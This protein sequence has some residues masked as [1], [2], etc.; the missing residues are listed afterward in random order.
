MWPQSPTIMAMHFGI[1]LVCFA[2]VFLLTRVFYETATHTPRVRTSN[3]PLPLWYRRATWTALVASIGVAYIG[4]YMRH[5]DATLACYR[6]PACTDET[7]P[8]LSGPVAVAMGH[9]L[10]ALA[11]IFLVGA[12]ARHTYRHREIEPDLYRINA[13]AFILI[14]LQALSGGAVV[15]TRL[16]TWSPL[17]HAALMALLFLC[18]ADA[19]RQIAQRSRVTAEQRL[20]LATATGQQLSPGD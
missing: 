14:V 6:W 19:C 2:S 16:D 20:Q 8:S 13:A 11:L 10:A 4:A 9:R 1:S 5:S 3:A 17:L 12:I 18:L 15:M 7:I